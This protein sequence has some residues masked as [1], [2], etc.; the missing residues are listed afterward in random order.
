MIHFFKE[1]EILSAKPEYVNC[2]EDGKVLAFMRKG[3]LFVFN[4]NPEISYQNYLIDVPAGK[5]KTVL[6]SDDE[7]YGG[8]SRIDR[9]TEHFTIYGEDSKN[10]ISL[11]LPSRTAQVLKIE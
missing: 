6:D 11:Y 9:A 4:F 8:F 10:R 3:Y 1:N 5:W 2:N 7:R